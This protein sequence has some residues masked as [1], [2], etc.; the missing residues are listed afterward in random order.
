MRGLFSTPITPLPGS[1][2]HADPHPARDAVD[3]GEGGRGLE[4]LTKR[5]CVGDAH[6]LPGRTSRRAERRL[7]EIAAMREVEE[8]ALNR[9][10]RAPLPRRD[11]QRR[12]E[13]GMRFR[14]PRTAR[15]V[16]QVVEGAGDAAKA[17]IGFRGRSGDRQ[18]LV[19]QPFDV[20]GSA[21]ALFSGWVVGASGSD[22][23]DL[24]EHVLG[25]AAG[26]AVNEDA[27][28]ALPDREA[29]IAVGV[30][31]ATAHGVVAVP[32]AAEGADDVHDG[33]GGFQ[34]NEGHDRSFLAAS[35]PLLSLPR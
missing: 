22:A 20:G 11:Q 1:F 14:S 24:A 12:E 8:D 29:G 34:R 32:G 33:L 2:F 16:A 28:M 5:Q 4:P 10:Q 23:R 19:P 35:D 21:G 25:G 9:A 17:E 30:G 27:V 3:L 31:R 13:P 6:A 26:E 7:V 18:P 15:V